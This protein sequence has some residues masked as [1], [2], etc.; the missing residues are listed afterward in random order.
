MEISE[1]TGL[2]E[3]PEG[4]FWRVGAS[5]GY[6]PSIF[7]A[8]KPAYIAIMQRKTVQKSQDK[9]IRLPF[10]MEFAWGYE[11]V[12]VEEIET[13]LSVDIF[14][15][16]KAT[17]DVF[18]ANDEKIGIRDVDKVT[19]VTGDDLTPELIQSAAESCFARWGEIIKSN[20]LLGDYP[21]KTLKDQ[22]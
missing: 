14:R 4:Y 17:E 15:T 12:P 19:R 5:R 11:T 10:G 22:K 13:V 7:T 9:M 18:D 2:P 3:L 16:E 21:P 20:D 6:Y 8:P 1:L